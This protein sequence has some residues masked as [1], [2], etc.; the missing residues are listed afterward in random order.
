MEML[1][2]GIFMIL[3]GLGFVVV[4]LWQMRVAENA[5]ADHELIE[6][7]DPFG[8]GSYVTPER[9]YKGAVFALIMGV[10]LILLGIVFLLV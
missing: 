6:R 5:D 10:V 2:L 8:G 3:F 1:F 4:A 7:K 9:L